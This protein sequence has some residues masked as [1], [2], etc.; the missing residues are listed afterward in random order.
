LT[1]LSGG[2]SGGSC[3]SPSL[4]SWFFI[5]ATPESWIILSALRNPS[6]GASASRVTGPFRRPLDAC[7]GGRSP[8]AIPCRKDHLGSLD[9]PCPTG[10]A[11]PCA[12]FL[13]PTLPGDP[14][15]RFP[16]LR[17]MCLPSHNALTGTDVPSRLPHWQAGLRGD[18][19]AAPPTV[20][21]CS[22][23]LRLN[24]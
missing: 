12:L 23:A 10:P 11:F 6:A 24:T 4:V 15:R 21:R 13:Q 17:T 22:M 16:R 1:A 2:L 7:P 8:H 18:G 20:C 19:S 5:P 9:V 14:S 3:V